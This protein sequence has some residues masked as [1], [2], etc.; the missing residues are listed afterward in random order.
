MPAYA[1]H[2]KR[3]T[4]GSTS[5]RGA[6]LDG[7]LSIL[8]GLPKESKL[9]IA[10]EPG[11]LAALNSFLVGDRTVTALKV[12]HRLGG[13]DDSSNVRLRQCKTTIFYSPCFPSV[14][15]VAATGSTIALKNAAFAVIASTS[16]L[17]DE[18]RKEF[19]DSP[20]IVDLLQD[21]LFNTYSYIAENASV[22]ISNLCIDE[23]TASAV[24]DNHPDLVQAL[25]DT[26]STSGVCEKFHSKS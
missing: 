13:R 26:F 5:E 7:L 11:L 6:G 10:R 17:E 1:P 15:G 25:V 2:V 20:G 18:R 19:L 8:P 24:L 12:L 16:G 23:T 3:M 14:K 22:T 4:T 9:A 21:G